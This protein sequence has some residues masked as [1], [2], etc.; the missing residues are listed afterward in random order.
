MN[1]KFQYCTRPP[2]AELKIS[3]SLLVNSCREIP[4]IHF[5]TALTFSSFKLNTLE[6]KNCQSLSQLK[7]WCDD[8]GM[9]NLHHDN[10]VKEVVLSQPSITCY[11]SAKQ[12]IGIPT[13]Y[14]S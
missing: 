4:I 12:K 8:S 9:L 13:V 1:K 14:G 5:L 2:S 6:K 3:C 7:P 11:K 10:D